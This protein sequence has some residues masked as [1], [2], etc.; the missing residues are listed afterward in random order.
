MYYTYVLQSEK[1][2]KFYTGFTSNL[3]LRFEQLRSLSRSKRRNEEGKIS[4]NIPW[5]D[6]FKKE[7]QI[8][9]NRVKVNMVRAG[10]V[11]HPSEYSFCG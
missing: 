10:G 1:D 9:F 2:G 11:R 3:K 8:L 4:Q 6:V 7:A 5:K